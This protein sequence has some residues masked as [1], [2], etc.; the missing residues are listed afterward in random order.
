MK[1]I[2]LCRHAEPEASARGRFC[3]A[4]EVG[5]SAAGRAEAADLAR[6]LGGAPSL[7]SAPAPRATQTARPLGEPVV[8]ERLRELDFGSFDGLTFDE[9][10]AGWPDVYAEY[11][12]APTRVRFPGGETFAELRARAL[13]VAGDVLG[14]LGDRTAVLVTHAGVIRAL[15]AAWLCLPD[16]AVFRIDQR[17]AAVNVIDWP[18][19]TPV[20]R[21]LNA[22]PGTVV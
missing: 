15:L 10:A 17:Y 9:A 1:R 11:L 13:D 6:G 7:Y 5:L 3:G 12:R 16:E 20:V 4:S 2:V 8:D 14:S 19:G 21:L 22:P 18:D